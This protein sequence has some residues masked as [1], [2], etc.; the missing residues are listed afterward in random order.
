[1]QL[2]KGILVASLLAALLVN[3][4]TE[5]AP[6]VPMAPLGPDSLAE[7]QTGTFGF[8]SSSDRVDRVRYI[9]WWGDNKIDTSGYVRAGDTV[10]LSHAWSDSGLFSLRCRAQSEAGKLSDFSSA[11]A[12]LVRNYPPAT[13]AV[14]G[15]AEVNVESEAEFLSVSTDPEGDIINYTFAW[16]DGDTVVAPGYG[17]GDT[18]R[19]LHS[20]SLP[21]EYDVKTMASDLAGHQSPWSPPHGVVVAP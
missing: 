8:Y 16:G 5:S 4:V 12:V 2:N 7:H 15:P 18:A 20:W 17:S 19:M 1:M 9:A 10:R 13:P 21:G 14:S 6:A 3:C 11:H